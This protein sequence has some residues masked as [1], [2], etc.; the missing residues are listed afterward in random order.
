MV[1]DGFESR[2]KI[3]QIIANQLPEFV[4]D[5]SPKFSEF[6]KQYYISQEFQGG[7]IDLVENLDQYLKLDNFTPEVITGETTLTANLSQSSTVIQVESTKGFPKSYGLLKIDDE[8]ITYTGITTN[9]FTGCIRGFSGITDYHKELNKQELIFTSSNSASHSELS[10]VENLSTLFL[11]EFYN[12]IKYTLTPGLENISLTSELNTGNFIKESSSLYKSKGTDESFRILFNALFNETPKVRNLENLLIKSSSASYVRRKVVIAEVISGNPLEL[13]GQ[14]LIKSTDSGSTASISEVEVIRRK[15]KTYYKLLLFV[16]YDDSFP[17]ITGTFDVTG[18]TKNLNTVNVGSSVI[19]VDSTIGFPSS[20]LIFCENN[21]ITYTNKTIN[22]FLGCSGINVEIPIASTIYSEDTYYGYEGGDLSKKVELRITGVLTDFNSINEISSA[23][24]GE[25][26]FVKNIGEGIENPETNPSKKEI[27][28]NSWIYNTKSRFQIEYFIDANNDGL[29]EQ[30]ALKSSIDKSSLKVGDS[31]EVLLRDSEVVSIANL[32]VTDIT[33]KIISV[34]QP[35]ATNSSFRYDIRRIIETGLSSIVPLEYS[36]TFANI[37]NVYNENN[38]YMY[39]AS[40]SV[41]SYEIT[42]PV[43]SYDA[44]GIED[45]DENTGLYSKI[46]FSQNISFTT[47]AEVYYKPSVTKIQGLEEGTYY[48]EVLPNLT[49]IRLYSSRSVIGTQ[50][51]VQFANFPGGTHNFTLLQ[52]KEKLISQQKLLKKFPINPDISSKEESITEVGTTGLLSNGVEILNYKS[53]NKIYYGPLESIRVLNSGTGYDVINPPLLSLDYGN[54]AIQPVVNGSLEKVYVDPQDFDIDIV[55][56]IA[57]TG[58]NG[59]GAVLEPIVEK[60]LRE[61]SFD[62][63]EL[64][65]NGSIDITNETITFKTPHGLSNG[66]TIFYNPQNNSPLGIGT[67]NGSNSSTGLTL[68]RDSQYIVKFI[69]DRTIQLY[70]SISDYNSGINTVGFTTVGTSGIHKFYTSVKNTLSQIKVVNGG[71]G[72]E[73][74]KLRVLPTGIS[75]SNDTIFFK[76]HGFKDGDLISYD[77]QTI[78]VVGLN[79]SYN[80]YVLKIDNDYFQLSNAGIGGT[81]SVDYEKRKNIKFNSI[82]SGYQIFKYPDISLAVNYSAVGVGS[83]QF[84][85]SIVATPIIRGKIID[86]YLYENGSDYGSTILNYHKKPNVEIKSGNR[87]QIN[88]IIVD[89]KITDISILYGGEEYYSQPDLKVIGIGTGAVLRPVIENNKISNV[90][91][92]NGGY[93]YSSSNTTV[94]VESVGKNASIDCQV[95]SISINNNVFYK[96]IDDTSLQNNGEIVTSSRNNLQYFISA[97]PNK[98]QNIFNDSSAAHSPI[99]GWAYDGNPIY[100]SYGYS[101]PKDKNSAI[102]QLVSGYTLNSNNI[103]NR[104]SGFVNGFFVEDYKFT[105]S[106]DLDEYNGRFCITPE[107]PNGVYAYFAT[108]TIDINANVIGSFPYFIGNKYRSKFVSENKKIDQSFDFNNSKLVRN[109]FPHKLGEQYASNDFIIESNRIVNQSFVIESIKKG[110]IERF[111]IVNSGDNYKVNDALLL[112]EAN[113]N[114]FGLDAKVSEVE[115]KLIENLQTSSVEYQNAIFTLKNDSQVEVFVN[116]NGNSNLSNLDYVSISGFSTQLSLLNGIHQIGI[117]SYVST[118]EEL[119]PSYASTGIVTDIYV[120]NIPE[121]VSIGSSIKIDQETFSILNLYNRENVIRVLRD[122]VGVSHTATSQVYFI[123]DRFIID[124]KI[125]YVDSS[126][127][128]Y[129]YFNPKQSVG[130]GTTTGSTTV[131]KYKTGSKIKNIFVPTQSIYLPS[132]PFKT[133]QQVVLQKLSSSSALLVSNSSNGSTFNLPIS[134]DQQIVYIIN[135][136]PDHIGIV[137]QIG[138]TTSTNGLFFNNNGTDDYQYLIKSNHKQ[139]FGNVKKI[140]TRVSISTNHNLSNGDIINLTVKPNLS[141]GVGQSSY[142]R[143]KYDN[144]RKNLIVNSKDFTS[145]S[146]S[147]TTGEITII[148]HEFKTSDKVVY[149]SSN[150]AVGLTEG[151]YYIFKVDNDRVK[152]CETLIDSK[153]ESPITVG[154]T[155]A[156]SAS[157]SLN[158]INPPLYPIKGN[159]LLFD[160]SDSSLNGYNLKIFYDEFFDKEF[161]STGIGTQFSITGTGSSISLNYD[162]TINFPLFY[163]LEKSGYISTADVEVQNHSQINFIDSTYNGIYKISGIGTTT[164]DI[165]L[166]KSPERNSYSQSEC[167]DLS[168]TTTSTSAF[169]PIAKIKTIS[170]GL[171]YKKLPLFQTVVTNSGSNAY[172]VPESDTIGKVGEIRILNNGFEYASDKTLRPEALIS[173]IITIK[174]SYSISNIS[175]LDGGKNYISAPNIIVFDTQTGRKLDSGLLIPNLVSSSIV[176]VTI[177]QEPKGITN[178]DV[179]LR[180]INN[181]NGVRIES[182]ESSS[183]GIVTCTLVTPLSGFS[184]EP[185]SIGDRIY[186]EGIEK[187]DSTGDG[188]NSENYSYQFFTV[189]N[190]LNSGTT[191]PRKLEFTGVSTNTGI[192]KT[193]QDF[194]ASVIN[195]K[196]YPKFSAVKSDTNFIIGENI[197]MD[198]GFGFG[199]INVKIVESNKNFIK[200]SGTFKFKENDVLRGIQSGTLATIDKIKESFGYFKVGYAS[201]QLIGWEN[202]IGKLDEDNQ[203]IADNDY[204]QNLSYSIKSKQTWSDIVSPVNDLLHPSGFKNFADTEI[205]KNVNVGITTTVKEYTNILYKFVTENRVD[206]INNFDLTLDID[207]VDTSSVFLKLK[208]KKLTDYIEVK[209]NRVLAIDDISL[210]FYSQDE[211]DGFDLKYNNIPIFMKTF[212]PSNPLVLNTSTAKFSINDHFFQTGEELFYRPLTSVGSAGTAM[213]IGTTL[214]YSG[215]STNILPSKVYA[216]RIDNDNFKIATRKDY[217]L[218]NPPIPV[219]ITNVGYGSSHEFEM[220]K[221]N[222]KSLI[223]VNNMAQS[224]IAYSLLNYNIDNGSSIGTASS[225]F[226]LTGISSIAPNDILKVDDEY[227]KVINVGFGTS[228]SGPISFAGT[229]PLVYV[230]RGFVGSSVT[231]HSGV[232][233]ATVYRGSFNIERNKIYFTESLENTLDDEEFLDDSGLSYFNSTF[234]GRVFLRKDYTTNQ[235]FDNISERFTG[236]GQTYTITVGGANTVGLGTTAG[237]GIVF[238]NGIFQTPLTENNDLQV[239]NN[240]SVIENL[241]VGVSSIVFSGVKLPNGNQSIV[242]YDV[243]MNEL[244]RGG[245]IVSLGSTPGL[246][247]APLVGA[248]VTAIVGAGGSIVAIGIGTTGNWG[249]GYRNPVSIAITELGHSGT[250]SSITATVGLGGTLSFNI[251]VGGSGYTNPTINISPPTYSNLPVIGV[252][253]L[254][255]GSTTSTGVGLLVDV[256]VGSSSTTGIGSTLFQVTNFKIARNGFGFQR[257]DIVTPV[258]LVT[259]SKLSSPISRFELTVL[260]TFT[261]SFSGWQFGQIDY[262]DNIKNYQDGSRTRFPLYYNSSLL[263]FEKNNFDVESQLI[264]DFDSLL[265][266]FVNGVLQEPGVSYQFTGGTTFTFSAPPNQEDNISIFFYRGSSEDSSQVNISETIKD[267]DTVQ[268]L[269]NNNYLGITTS[270]TARVVT[271]ILSSDKIQTNPYNSEGIDTKLYKPLSWTK[272]KVDKIINGQYIYKSR[273]SIETQ[274]YPTAKIINN[275]SASDS[276]LFVDNAALFDYENSLEVDFDAIIVSGEADPVSAS[277]MA[278]VSAASTISSISVINGGSGYTPGSTFTINIANPI[279]SGV[280]ATATATVSSNGTV[281][282]INIINPGLGY[283][284][285]N[286][287]N[288]LIP[289]PDLVLDKLVSASTVEGF[290]GYITGIQTVSG[291]GTNMAIRFTLNSPSGFSGLSTGYPIYIYDTYVGNGVTSIINHN[292]SIVGVGTSFLDNIYYIQQFNASVGI[293]TCNIHSQTNVVGIATT[294]SI[295]GKFSWGRISGFSR[296]APVAIAVSGY[297]VDVGLTT[298]PTIQRRGYGLRNIG[299]LK[300]IL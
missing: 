275:L 68:Q 195:Y 170:S 250:L 219:T 214:S 287:P 26:I 252:S 175:V 248:S 56:S 125:G 300:K 132:H 42:I 284:S 155:S 95:R 177:E 58:G 77:Y 28:A 34:S 100:G 71:S 102:K 256:E 99:I 281:S 88:P 241:N 39:V 123:P 232:S 15:N 291:I 192:A 144:I 293:I 128:D 276:E 285:T 79:T 141:I 55:V 273:D 243:N 151:I 208:N 222:E 60:R 176:G 200:V 136:S 85:G 180:A 14:T 210:E 64:G 289:F 160:L 1:R 7:P 52:Q 112:D 103:F 226:P 92:I 265:I 97:Y 211:N 264:N 27:F 194:Y 98:I 17:T 167:N 237:N 299:P 262:I 269:Q 106:G 21:E 40:N 217:A 91:I 124:K 116:S 118:L 142:V 201:T 183:S 8:I 70:Q 239:G 277:A 203:V 230:Q 231:T 120:S 178:G 245:L 25:Y 73:N 202:D 105:N 149:T 81:Y 37:Q 199:N 114:G 63:K 3:Q 84:R 61:I 164:F 205:L 163:A 66:Q 174:N 6:L 30:F 133:N 5:E 235:I 24:E 212:D 166:T 271:E 9:T 193:V 221:R 45:L 186:V 257:G 41:P 50:N 290:S 238:L 263:S 152:L 215:I 59:S 272:Q 44:L 94:R 198:R 224:P 216:I 72:Y 188:F 140:T 294:G 69:N 57:L 54:A 10:T 171:N 190:Y 48:V 206:T 184:Q 130:I 295:V 46:V 279:G 251:I 43:F 31:I 283:T 65:Y 169:G 110:S 23:S 113:T 161:V 131:L 209:T 148:N 11:Q 135:K 156:P 90:V 246:G 108:S 62:A 129:L 157:H 47:G 228:S 179:D 22:Q 229:F 185:F 196:N 261:D 126:I 53:S 147:T 134:G 137:T 93:G 115:G 253:R 266:I 145:S 187:Y 35:F 267:G 236:I 292:T 12:K 260:D 274:I 173:T 104:P 101:D 288:I 86:A 298:F 159:N 162:D 38:E 227:M 204:Y 189:S 75:T 2:V 280:T 181:T 80:Y 96:D 240:Y 13:R 89:G 158:P 119:V 297:T 242:D 150:V 78:G 16:G 32:Q 18:S 36:E 76:N 87:A 244:P 282:S 19:T 139:L 213:G 225:I 153:Y 191:L 146:I 4:L 168:Y 286:K 270:Q 122:S 109:T 121:N 259:D 172:I 143:L 154:I 234:H 20:G 51:Y 233:T 254:S 49:S 258:G 197:E 165:L 127:N 268:V 278:T 223:T 218:A 82:G 67:F 83:T 207:T 255:T 33:D 111:N 247:Y 138:L 107:F 296:Q 29:A 117:T 74:R 182:V 249:S 220:V